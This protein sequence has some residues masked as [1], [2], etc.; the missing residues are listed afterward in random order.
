M[1][2]NDWTE[3]QYRKQ[4]DIFKNKLR[5]FEAV[6]RSR[7]VKEYEKGGERYRQSPQDVLYKIAKSK[8][9]Y[10]AEYEPSQ[11]VEQIQAVT[12][13]SITKGKRIAAAATSASYK[14]AVRA[15]VNIR[16]NGF[17]DFYDKAQEIVDTISD[18]IKQEEALKAFANYLHR[19]YPRAG[20]DKGAP[21]KSG[22]EVFASGET[23]GSDINMS[24]DMGGD[25]DI[26]LYL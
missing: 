16:F 4:Y 7:G 9:R 15:I 3:E 5:F 26:S 14:N 20:K 24:A 23:Y 19:L 13:H 8:M 10:G 22:G 2:A 25:F 17:I 18:P 12:A 21:T 1:A 6:Q 11:E